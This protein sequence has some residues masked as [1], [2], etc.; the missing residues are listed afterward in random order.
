MFLK[1]FDFRYFFISFTIGIFYIY[2]T[3]EHKKV[4]ILYPNPDNLEKYTY[5]DKS[6]N[7]FNYE[8]DETECPTDASNRIDVEVSY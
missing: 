2:L 7:C 5:V 1:H 3:N 4:I 8:L 6:D